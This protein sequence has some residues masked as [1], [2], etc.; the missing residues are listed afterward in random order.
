MYVASTKYKESNGYGYFR[1]P[2]NVLDYLGWGKDDIIGFWIIDNDDDVQP[3]KRTLHLQ[4]I[5]EN[6]D[7]KWCKSIVDIGGGSFGFKSIP[8]QV[9]KRLELKIGDEL[10]FLP[11]SETW[12]NDVNKY[13]NKLQDIVFVAKNSKA[14]EKYDKCPEESNN[15]EEMKKYYAKRYGAPF[16]QGRSELSDK[17]NKKAANKVVRINTQINKDKIHSIEEEIDRS[18]NWIKYVSKSNHPDKSSILKKHKASMQ[19][20]RL[21]KTKL[22]KNPEKTFEERS[23]KEKIKSKTN[24]GG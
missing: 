12:L 18:K 2:K 8:K 5:Q 9:K 23:K 11:A 19:R 24:N 3:E 4:K 21:L 7:K 14:L 13:K 22:T 17:N 10:Y 15:E 6:P 1:F 20:F 16:F